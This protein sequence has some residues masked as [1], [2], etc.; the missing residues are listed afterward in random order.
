[1]ASSN[2]YRVELLPQIGLNVYSILRNDTLLITK[3]AV[4]ILNKRLS[5]Y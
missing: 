5:Q 1:M 3:E 2:I 4:E